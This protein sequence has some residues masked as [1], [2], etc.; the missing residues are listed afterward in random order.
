MAAQPA[1]VDPHTPVVLVIDDEDYVAD[2]VATALGLE[3]YIVHVAY[4]GRQ[5]FERAH[6]LSVDL[7]IIDLMMPY[8]G[9]EE[10]AARL[11]EDPHAGEVPIILISAGAS[12]QQLLDGITFVAKPFDIGR[13]LALVEARIGRPPEGRAAQRGER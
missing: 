5:G 9:G 12:P 3:G 6:S 1:S 10:L 13:L 7:V 8:L 4:N 2:M 11:R